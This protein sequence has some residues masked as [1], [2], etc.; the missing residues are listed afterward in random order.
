MHGCRGV[1][2]AEEIERLQIA[3][4]SLPA[5]I[6]LVLP[7]TTKPTSY[8]AMPTPIPSL[9]QLGKKITAKR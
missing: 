5:H 3:L 7:G 6:E 1:Y 4:K 8:H 9:Q 2:N